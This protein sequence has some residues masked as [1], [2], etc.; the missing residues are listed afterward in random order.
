M[1]RRRPAV[2][3]HECPLLGGADIDSPLVSK[4]PFTTITRA[5][6]G[7][8]RGQSDTNQSLPRNSLL[9]GNLQGILPIVASARP[10][11]AYACPEKSVA[12]GG[13]PYAT[14]QGILDAEQANFGRLRRFAGNEK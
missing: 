3:V 10:I 4:R 11:L 7:A 6:P 8:T 2:R 12:S 13:I 9:A 5:E 14:E 1:V